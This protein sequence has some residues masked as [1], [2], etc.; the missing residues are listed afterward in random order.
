MLQ[1]NKN[2]TISAISSPIGEG[3]IA[4][5]RL[6]GKNTLNIV[7]KFFSKDKIQRKI[8]KRVMVIDS[9]IEVAEKVKSFLDT[10]PEIERQLGKNDIFRL[11]VSDITEQFEKTAGMT[12][13][14]KVFLEHVKP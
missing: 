13:K 8:G 2:D 7:N 1:Y 9:S 12:L 10:N 11:F 4:I 5:V 6:S 3:A 14:R